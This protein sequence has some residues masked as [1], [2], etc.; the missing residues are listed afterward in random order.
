MSV[1]TQYCVAI[2][3]RAPVS[4]HKKI[5]LHCEQRHLGVEFLLVHGISAFTSPRGITSLHNEV[6]LNIVEQAVVVVLDSAQVHV[7]DVESSVQTEDEPTNSQKRI[8][9]RPTRPAAWG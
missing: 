8:D 6:A 9:K 1:L 4:H 3:T 5:T 7:H 2:N